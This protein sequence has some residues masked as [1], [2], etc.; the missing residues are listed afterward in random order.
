MNNLLYTTITIA[1]ATTVTTTAIATATTTTTAAAA[2]TTTTTIAST[3]STTIIVPP[4]TNFISSKV[5]AFNAV[6]GVVSCL[7]IAIHAVVAVVV[8]KA[9]ATITNTISAAC[10]HFLFLL[11]ISW[12]SFLQ[13]QVLPLL[14]VLLFLHADETGGRLGGE[15]GASSFLPPP[16]QLHSC[17]KITI[18]CHMKGLRLPAATRKPRRLG[19]GRENT[20]KCNSKTKKTQKKQKTS[21]SNLGV[22][23]RFGT[24]TKAAQ[25]STKPPTPTVPTSASQAAQLSTSQYRWSPHH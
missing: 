10:C 9:I 15:A 5:L 16:L 17:E 24:Q 13:P 19:V 4:T 2:T 7:L 11:Y 1:I 6:S 3:T 8:P 20:P 18:Y 12:L 22:R 25:N 14:L 23:P 21:K